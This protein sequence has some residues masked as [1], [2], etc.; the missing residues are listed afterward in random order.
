MKNK[1]LDLYSI[2]PREEI[3]A[4]KQALAKTKGGLRE[5][6]KK[7]QQPDMALRARTYPTTRRLFKVWVVL[8]YSHTVF[9]IILPIIL[10][11]LTR[12]YWAFASILFDI[13]I[14]H[15]VHNAVN[16]ELFT[17]VYFTDCL[18]AD[19]EKGM[20]SRDAK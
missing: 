18:V 8:G 14:V 10:L 5:A 19:A 20:Q 12:W 2:I 13:V 11:F 17:R 7:L 15:T 9:F 1:H 4:F 6:T 3:S 16:I